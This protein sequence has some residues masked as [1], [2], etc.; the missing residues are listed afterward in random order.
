[1]DKSYW[2]SS[3]EKDR[4]KYDKLV[5]KK[6]AEI[7]IIGGGLTGLT[8]AYYLA[9]LGKKVVVLEKDKI[10]SHTSGNTTA[11]ITSQHRIILRLFN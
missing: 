2:I 4:E 7:C 5:S 6:E 8:C 11:K 1:M 3:V 10:M 9:K